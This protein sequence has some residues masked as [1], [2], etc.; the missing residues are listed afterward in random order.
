M[1]I[2]WNILLGI[3]SFLCVAVLVLQGFA[4]PSL[5]RAALLWLRI[6]AVFF[7]QWLFARAFQKKW[8]RCLPLLLASL[9]TV[10]GYFLYLTSPSWRNATFGN[11]MSDYASLVLGCCAY[12]VLRWLLPR[13]FPRIRRSVKASL[14]RRKTSKIN[15][16]DMPR[17]R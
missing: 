8:L 1:K 6:G 7:A 11:F 17:F 10:W 12:W 13:L 9:A 2:V 16:E 4:L 15:K 14:K 3:L 5:P